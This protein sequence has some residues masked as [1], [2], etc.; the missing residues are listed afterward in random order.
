MSERK[1]M[2]P[3][4]TMDKKE[5]VCVRIKKRQSLGKDVFENQ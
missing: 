4:N 5:Y 3:K 2:K 1:K